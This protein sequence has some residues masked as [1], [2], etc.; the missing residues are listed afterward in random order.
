MKLNYALEITRPDFAEH[1]AFLKD[2]RA[3]QVLIFCMLNPE[4]YQRT[5]GP[6]TT[7]V[8]VL[9]RLE[10]QVG[11]I[12]AQGLGIEALFFYPGT[13]IPNTI[14]RDTEQQDRFRALCQTCGRLGIRHLGCGPRLEKRDEPTA[15]WRPDLIAGTRFMGEAAAAEGIKVALH[16]NMMT[17]S[18]MDRPEDVE[19]FFAEVGR[20]NVGLMFCFGCI[21]LAGLDVPA[22][23]RR[24]RERIFVVDLRDVLGT[25][26]ENPAECQLGTGRIDL[27]ASVR[28]LREIGYEGVV[29]PEHF[30]PMA[31]DRPLEERELFN[32]PG[33]RDTANIAWTLGYC[34]ALL[35]STEER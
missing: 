19:E 2:C 35:E 34:R 13:A 14:G 31:S 23:I 30:P 18:R 11:E 9:Q 26:T 17:G 33:D 24:W 27:P 21:A 25:W 20:E 8:E 10:Q 7:Y 29:R 1:V 32:L 22:M 16:V 5:F 4:D 28:A 12:H 15:E 6:Q 3:D